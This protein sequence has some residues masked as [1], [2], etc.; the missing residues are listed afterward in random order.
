MSA[1][2]FDITHFGILRGS[3]FIAFKSNFPALFSLL[4]KT[5]RLMWDITGGASI[6]IIPIQ[7]EAARRTTTIT[8]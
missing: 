3:T 4:N 5:S 1:N 7:E 8:T 6:I 2:H